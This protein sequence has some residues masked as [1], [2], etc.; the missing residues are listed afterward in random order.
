[1]R[2]DLQQFGH[3]QR[4]ASELEYKFWKKIKPIKSI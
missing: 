1:M 2:L 3:V 4:N